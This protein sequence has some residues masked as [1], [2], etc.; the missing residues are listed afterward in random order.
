MVLAPY[1]KLTRLRKR[2]PARD[3]AE[4][5]PEGLRRIIHDTLGGVNVAQ[6]DADAALQ[7]GVRE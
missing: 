2:E 4:L 1:L 3:L 5:P 7:R 6:V